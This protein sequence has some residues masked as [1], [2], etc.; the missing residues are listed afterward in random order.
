MTD[1]EKAVFKVII[2]GTIDAVWREITKTDELQQC[3]FNARMHT[4]GLKPGGQIRMR[5][6]SGKFT[7]VVGEVLEFDPPHRF[8]HTFKFT[9]YDDPPC[10]VTYELKEVSEGVEFTLS[11]DNMPAG[12]KTAKQMTRGGDFIVKTL[13]EIVENGQPSFGTRMLYTVFKVMEPF[14]PKSSRTENWPI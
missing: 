9:T 11:V 13:K 6:D 7:N 10:T 14:S 2:K 3:M 12:T 5:T 4:D 1:T 8:S